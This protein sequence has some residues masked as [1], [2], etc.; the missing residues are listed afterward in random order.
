MF[1]LRYI[2][3][4]K[5]V[6]NC[7]KTD[8]IE[9][10][11]NTT[12]ISA[13]GA[14]KIL[15][16]IK[17]SATNASLVIPRRSLEYGLHRIDVKVCMTDV[18]PIVCASLA[19]HI[20]IRPSDLVAGFVGGTGRAAGSNRL[21]TV[22]ANPSHDPDVGDTNEGLSFSWYCK[23]QLEVFPADLTNLT[24]NVYPPT[25]LTNS[26]MNF[27][28]SNFKGCFGA[29]M[30]HLKSCHNKS[31]CALNSTF[32]PL[33][34]YY[35]VLLVVCKRTPGVDRKCVKKTYTLFVVPG[36]PPQISIR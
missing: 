21:V 3:E 20:V 17:D 15:T 19:G 16:T 4:L 25:P 12:S 27:S 34:Q 22:D 35:N 10:N 29:G 2:C 1:I 36:N 6:K 18:K 31:E 23:Q 33:S 9:F 5:V 32:T 30:G 26:S 13:I 8:K 11:W 24:D 28:S 14:E 7:E